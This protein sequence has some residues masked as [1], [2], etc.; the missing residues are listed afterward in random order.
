M[1]RCGMSCLLG[2]TVNQIVL[3]LPQVSFSDKPA[4][5]S[6]SEASESASESE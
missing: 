4:A 3:M 1:R 6:G 2:W 5:A